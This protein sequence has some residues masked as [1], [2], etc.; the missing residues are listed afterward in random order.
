MNPREIYDS[1][2]QATVAVIERPENPTPQRP[3]K[4]VGSGFCVHAAG[5]V[6]TCDHV[7]QRFLKDQHHK[8]VLKRVGEGVHVPTPISVFSILFY[9]GAKGSKVLMHEG[10]VTEVAVVK[11]F[12][13]AIFKVRKHGAF[14]DGLPTLDVAEYDDLHEMMDVGT[15]GYPFGDFLWSQ[16]GSAT[17]SFSK[18]TMSSII[19]AQGVAR[20]HLKGFQLDLLSAPGN[21]GGPVFCPSTGKVFG[22]LQ[23]GPVDPKGNPILGLTIAEPV[24]HDQG[25]ALSARQESGR[26][27]RQGSVGE[28]EKERAE[29]MRRVIDGE[30]VSGH[31]VAPNYPSLVVSDRIGEGTGRTICTIEAFHQASVTIREDG[32]VELLIGYMMPE[33]QTPVG[34]TI[35]NGVVEYDDGLK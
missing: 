32:A 1:I 26:G 17:S 24:E 4:I 13:I 5:I 21:S 19:P 22:V 14:P 27:F 15:C 30:M 31:G 28:G 18:G 12:D 25:P 20:E 7:F 8:S 34:L 3:F 29:M 11:N 6:L 9:G 35:T 10:N 23:G 2:K 33:M 16:V